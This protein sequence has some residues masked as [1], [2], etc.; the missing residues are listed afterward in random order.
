[1]RAAVGFFA[2]VAER[3]SAE[4]V[5]VARPVQTL[6]A[7]VGLVARV[8][9]HVQLQRGVGKGSVAAVN[10]QIRLLTLVHP[11]LV[12][13]NLALRSHFLL[14]DVTFERLHL[15]QLRSVGSNLVDDLHVLLQLFIVLDGAAAVWA[16]EG[17]VVQ[18]GPLMLLH[19][20]DG[21][22]LVLAGVA[23]VEL[24]V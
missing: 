19:D 8:R 10:A 18:V 17:L 11:I 2:G 1:M 16:Q 5:V 22:A 6:L 4:R 9:P 21:E 13:A 3:V 12:V 7:G 23:G 15:F 24:H 20:G 14:T